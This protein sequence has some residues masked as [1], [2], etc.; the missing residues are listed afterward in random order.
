MKPSLQ[1]VRRRMASA[2][3]QS[4]FRVYYQ[5]I[6]DVSSGRIAGV[7]ALCRWPQRN[8]TVAMPETFIAQAETSGFIVELGDW[9]LRTAAVQ[10]RQW[11]ERFGGPARLAVNLSGRQFLHFNLLD[12]VLVALQDAAFDPRALDVEITETTAMQNAE[13]SIAVMHSLKAAG[14]G[15]SLDD[16]GTGYS[17]L[18]YLKRF[19]IDTLKIDKSFVRD[20]LADESDRAIVTA[21]IAMAQALRLN[22]IAE[23]V[24]TSAQWHYVRRSGARYAQGYYVGHPM[25]APEFERYLEHQSENSGVLAVDDAS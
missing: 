19:P 3:N 20:I 12:Q 1:P 8:K 22:V 9:V 18:S 24:E 15:L 14:I 17:S 6:A 4:E 10:V 2:L 25:P 13:E 5:A 23:G 21:I 11:Q 16:F 7:E